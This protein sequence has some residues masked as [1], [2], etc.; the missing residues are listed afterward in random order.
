LIKQGFFASLI[1]VNIVMLFMGTASQVML[2]KKRGAKVG[3]RCE[4]MQVVLYCACVF[5]GFSAA[6][7]EGG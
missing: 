3:L 4:Q 5:V 2:S 6:S 1:Q 7:S